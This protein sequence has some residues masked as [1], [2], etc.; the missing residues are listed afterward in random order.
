[1]EAWCKIKFDEAYLDGSNPL[2][3]AH[4]LYMND[5]E[6]KDLTIPE[7]ITNLNKGAFYCASGLTSVTFP[8]SMK[9]ITEYAFFG[10]SGLTS[11]T[12]PENVTTIGTCCFYNC[13]SLKQVRM[14]AKT[15]ASMRVT[16]L[17]MS[18]ETNPLQKLNAL[19]ID[20]QRFVL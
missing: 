20:N 16:L 2:A 4:H 9:S 12:L 5:E 3:N 19:N 10:C 1:M 8:N 15:R 18:I 7:T 11:I 13:E 6:V 14:K 17:G